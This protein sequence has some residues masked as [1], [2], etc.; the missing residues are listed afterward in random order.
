MT[1]EA[2]CLNEGGRTYFLPY[3]RD[4]SA[5][6]TRLNYFE[7]DGPDFTVNEGL[8][9]ILRAYD[10]GGYLFFRNAFSGLLA[11]LRRIVTEGFGLRI[12]ATL[13]GVRCV[14]DLGVF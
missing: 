5:R 4:D 11:R 1:I 12:N 6:V 7:E 10:V 13:C 3:P 8:T 2:S 14:R 9:L